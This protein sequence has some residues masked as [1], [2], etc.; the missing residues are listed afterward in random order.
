MGPIFLPGKSTGVLTLTLAQVGLVQRPHTGQSYSILFSIGF[1]LII[2]MKVTMQKLEHACKS[3]HSWILS[4]NMATME[5][6]W[7]N[8]IYHIYDIQ[9]KGNVRKLYVILLRPIRQNK[10]FLNSKKYPYSSHI[11]INVSQRLIL[12][13]S[14]YLY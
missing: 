13:S 8:R 10:Y 11:W 2:L 12:H 3:W 4:W 14:L 6:K 7:I 5:S 1:E 9:M